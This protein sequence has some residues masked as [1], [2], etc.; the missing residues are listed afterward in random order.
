MLSQSQQHAHLAS[1]CPVLSAPGSQLS[2]SCRDL[3]ATDGCSPTAWGRPVSSC[4][5]LEQAGWG[6]LSWQQW[7]QARAVIQCPHAREAG[8]EQHG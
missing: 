4:S 6:C 2:V 7:H 8:S 1:C 3:S 5:L